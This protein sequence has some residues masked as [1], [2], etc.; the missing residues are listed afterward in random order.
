M[1]WRPLGPF[2]QHPRCQGAPLRCRP[3]RGGGG[4]TPKGLVMRR[5]APTASGPQPRS[6]PRLDWGAFGQR[7]TG[8]FMARMASAAAHAN[9]IPHAE[10]SVA[11]RHPAFPAT[12][13]SVP[14]AHHEPQRTCGSVPGSGPHCAS[15]PSRATA[16]PW[17][18]QGH[19]LCKRD[20]AHR[21]YE[22]TVLLGGAG[23]VPLYDTG[24]RPSSANL[25]AMA[26]RMYA[27]LPSCARTFCHNVPQIPPSSEHCGCCA[28]CPLDA[29][30]RHR[31]VVPSQHQLCPCGF[32]MPHGC[33]V[34]PPSGPLCTYI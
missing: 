17:L 33:R 13:P 16:H 14:R 19:P 32:P 8:V 24:M 28:P 3:C 7:Q 21:A 22:S 2:P 23:E 15:A 1:R 4:A 9:T 25:S 31:S 5:D 29:K 10:T 20:W 34:A 18:R 12:A 27:P 6:P 30:S 26:R 11:T